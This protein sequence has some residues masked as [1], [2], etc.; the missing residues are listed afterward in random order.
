MSHIPTSKPSELPKLYLCLEVDQ[1][2][3]QVFSAYNPDYRDRAFVIVQQHPEY[4]MTS[5]WSCSVLAKR[6][7]VR[8]G[9]VLNRLKRRYPDLEIMP[10]HSGLEKI[11]CEDLAKL[12][13][14]YTPKYRVDEGGMCILDLSGVSVQ[15]KLEALAERLKKE[16]R[17]RIGF[18]EISVG[19]S[20]M[21]LLARLLAK[22]SLPDGVRMCKFGEEDSILTSLDTGLIFGLSD[23]CRKKIDKY[24]LKRIGQFRQLGKRALVHRFGK[25]GERLYGLATGI[26][27]QC[28][29]SAS[30]VVQ[31]ETVLRWDINDVS[32]LV[33][34]VQLM[35]DRFCYQL[36]IL[37]LQAKGITL[38]LKYRDNRLVWKAEQLEIPTNEFFRIAPLALRLF[39]NLYKR[40]VA[41][42]SIRLAAK[43]LQTDSGQLSLF[44]TDSE[45]R[46]RKI[47]QVITNIRKKMGFRSILS[48]SYLRVI[49]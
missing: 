35:S 3:A 18:S 40:R 21:K 47:D 46:C 41:A 17:S 22:A 28:Q 39:D 8:R 20:H 26:E 27:S 19:I 43:Q 32:L 14:D 30:R 11:S 1:F 9:M 38:T 33:Q 23:A 29:A 13:N 37:N 12:L 2:S 25:E 49:S 7:G 45:R 10:R 16:I 34:N 42:K 6:M 44:E 36:K 24:G 48:A 31:S 4:R 5:V 15:G